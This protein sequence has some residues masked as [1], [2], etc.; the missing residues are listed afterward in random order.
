MYKL[1]FTL[2]AL[3]VVESAIA[4]DKWAVTIKCVDAKACC[5]HGGVQNPNIANAKTLISFSVGEVVHVLKQRGNNLLV[6]HNLAGDQ[7][8]IHQSYFA[9]EADFQPFV[10]WRGQSEFIM[11]SEDGGTKRIY[12]FSRNGT[13]A[14]SESSDGDSSELFSHHKWSGQLYRY[15]QILWAKK[16]KEKDGDAN[17][18]WSVLKLEQDG[19]ACLDSAQASQRCK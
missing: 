3:L 19:T 11:F 8:W 17:D 6:G 9:R 2:L 14:A 15:K 7:A 4:S 5:S 13:F 16:R 1:L 10:D 18:K 12:Q